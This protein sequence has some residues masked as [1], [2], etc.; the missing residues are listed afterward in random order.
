MR[1]LPYACR[2]RQDWENAVVYA[3]KS[4]AM[5]RDMIRRLQALKASGMML[6]LKSDAPTD[7]EEQTPEHFEAVHDPASPLAVS[8]LSESEID[9]MVAD[10][11]GE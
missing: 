5:Q 8:G 7:P 11:G 2:T 1:G 6:V 3:R 9:K 10:L 4:A